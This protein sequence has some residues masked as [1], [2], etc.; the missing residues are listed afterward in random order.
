MKELEDALEQEREAHSRVS[1]PSYFICRTFH[2][3]FQ[4]LLL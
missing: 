4:I 1:I 2:S 3:A